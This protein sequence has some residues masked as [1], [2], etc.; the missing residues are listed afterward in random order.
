[1][2]HVSH[3]FLFVL[4]NF[5]GEEGEGWGG[6]GGGRVVKPK[7]IIHSHV[8]LLLISCLSILSDFLSFLV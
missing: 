5:D 8:V 7:T 6:G 4:I 2:Y 1:M 3:F